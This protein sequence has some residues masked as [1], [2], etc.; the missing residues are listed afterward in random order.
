M[1]KKPFFGLG[2]P[3]LKYTGIEDIEHD[4]QEIPLSDR[5]TLLL[6]ST[7]GDLD[8]L[9]LSTGAKVRTGERLKLTASNNRYLTSTATGTIT[10]I[11]QTKGYS[12][13]LFISV[14][15]DAEKKDLWDD[16]FQNKG[17]EPTPETALS[18][19]LSL[20]GISD[21]SSLIKTDNPLDTIIINGL[22]QD[23]LV[24]T[25]QLIVKNE[26]EN[27]AEGID[28]LKNITGVNRILFAVPPSLRPEAE[29]SGVEVKVIEPV[30]PNAMPRL[31]MKK[32]L[33]I[34]L[35][36]LDSCEDMGVGVVSA[37]AVVALRK[38]FV[39]RK[40]PIS[41]I[42]TVIDKE[43]R[44]I[45]VR[46]RIGTPVK[47][48]LTALNIN[49]TEGDRLVLGGP[50][51]GRGIYSADTPIRH[52]TDAIMV[53]DKGQVISGSNDPCIN[54][55]ECIRACPAA[56]PVNMLVRVLENGLYE[57]AANEYDLLSCVE[58]GL[59]SYV[60]VMRIPMFHYIMLGKHELALTGVL[61]ESNG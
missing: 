1:I 11:S 52:D 40:A 32:L 22:D 51:A 9:V 61:E 19:F 15:I 12:G 41:K 5:V 29:K 53:Q 39:H 38:A 27:L 17:K 23:L 20:P 34:T 42:L 2:K 16:G 13:Q 6:K 45:G 50:M 7:E 3:K 10:D 44:S 14:S 48:I 59:C 8:D 31:L 54:C 56:L 25:N 26:A 57:E 30:Y 46:A 58:C 4:I 37:E 24:A 55:G 18:F 47:D 28:Y 35:S 21:L 60:C 43:N 36:P 49:L 33:G